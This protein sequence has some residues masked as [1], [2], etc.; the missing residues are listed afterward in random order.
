MKTKDRFKDKVSSRKFILAAGNM[1]GATLIVIIPSIVN[2]YADTNIVLLSGSE[3][4]SLLIAVYTIY[5]GANIAQ[6]RLVD[7]PQQEMD[8]KESRLPDG[9]PKISADDKNE[10]LG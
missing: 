7:L 4:C 9:K 1:I 8:N 6:Q 2:F 10:G 5:S 3:Y